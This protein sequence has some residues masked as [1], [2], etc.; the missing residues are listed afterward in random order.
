MKATPDRL[1]FRFLPFGGVLSRL[2]QLLLLDRAA[3]APLPRTEPA[4]TASTQS[5]RTQL[6]CRPLA[7][8][9]GHRP[10]TSLV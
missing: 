1:R 5:R 8:K 2:S 4:A 9:S 3:G 6:A 7:R 10:A